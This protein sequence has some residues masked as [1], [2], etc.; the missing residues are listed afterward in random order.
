M[1]SS[2]QPPRSHIPADHLPVL[3]VLRVQS[4]RF[5]AL[6][7]SFNP[8]EFSMMYYTDPQSA[9][10]RYADI[11][12]AT[13]R[14]AS[15]LVDW[16]YTDY[17]VCVGVYA[18]D[19][20][21]AAIGFATPIRLNKRP[22]PVRTEPDKRTAKSRRST[23]PSEQSGI[24][25]INLSYV[26]HSAYE[27]QGF[28]Q[29]ASCLAIRAAHDKWGQLLEHGFLNIQTRLENTRSCALIERL[30]P[31]SRLYGSGFTVYPQGEPPVK[32]IGSRALWALA[33]QRAQNHLQSL[34]L[35]SDNGL[36]D[37]LTYL[38]EDDLN[39]SPQH[40]SPTT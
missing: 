19:Q 8:K 26:V 33:V 18:K 16:H 17:P 3:P 7:S 4:V 30:A 24:D 36:D 1:D 29:T 37:D 6:E 12:G 38:D 35:C 23:P 20:C 32:F 34:D 22:E 2:S 31:D 39:D 10:G 14:L 21:L 5:R 13:A 9:A 28:G 40:P 27:G 15:R 11:N 25:A